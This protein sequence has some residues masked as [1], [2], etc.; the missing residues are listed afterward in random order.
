MYKKENGEISERFAHPLN[1]VDNKLLCIDLTEF[2]SDDRQEYED[3]LNRIHSQYIQAIKEV[4]L[5][6]QFRYFFTDGISNV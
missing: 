1:L 5:G 4:G 6:S 2:D 3:I